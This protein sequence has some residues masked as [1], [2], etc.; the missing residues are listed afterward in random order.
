VEGIARYLGEL[1]ERGRLYI[2][3]PGRTIYEVAKAL[4]ME[5]TPFGVD[6]VYNMELVGRD[7][8]ARGLEELIGRY[9]RPYIVL[10]PIG[11]TGFLLGRGNQQITPKVLRAAGRDGIIIVM[12]PEKASKLATLLVDT[13]DK[14]LDRELEGYYR[15]ITGYREERIVAV[16]ASWS[17]NPRPSKT[18]GQSCS[19]PHL[20]GHRG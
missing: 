7:L 17:V 12:T 4:G 20:R 13:G 9:G 5:K 2:L 11:G 8:D 15:A 19:S 18:P 14:E 1:M 10:T 3:G 16:R 6:A